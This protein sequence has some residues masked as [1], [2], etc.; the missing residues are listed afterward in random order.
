MRYF[1]VKLVSLARCISAIYCLSKIG[2]KYSKSHRFRGEKQ[3][4]NYSKNSRHNLGWY[5]F[6]HRKFANRFDGRF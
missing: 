4:L 5:Y 2:F 3:N 6:Y 1:K